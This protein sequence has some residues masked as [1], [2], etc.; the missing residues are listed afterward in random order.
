MGS[1]SMRN[2]DSRDPRCERGLHGAYYWSRTYFKAT[3]ETG[4]SELLNHKWPLSLSGPRNVPFAMLEKGH[5]FNAA[6]TRV[7]LRTM[8]PAHAR[9]N[10]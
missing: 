10:S 3:L 9:R 4:L 5:A 8:S 1:S 7:S 2:L 6:R